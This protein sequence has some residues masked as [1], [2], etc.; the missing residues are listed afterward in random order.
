MPK[1][2]FDLSNFKKGSSKNLLVKKTKEKR[3]A[4]LRTYVTETQKKQFDE[5]AAD[6]G[7]DTAVFLRQ[8]LEKAKLI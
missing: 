4:V 1:T 3:S 6:E 7:L 5:L 8:I 2:E